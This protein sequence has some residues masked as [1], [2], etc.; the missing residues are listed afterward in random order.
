MYANILGYN[1]KRLINVLSYIKPG[2][3]QEYWFYTPECAQLASDAFNVPVA[4]FCENSASSLLFLPF[5]Q[6]PGCYKKPIILQHEHSHFVLIKLKPNRDIQ[7]PP[8][9]P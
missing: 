6:R 1:V 4:V 5:D 7:V 3:S 9:N 8:I 2:C